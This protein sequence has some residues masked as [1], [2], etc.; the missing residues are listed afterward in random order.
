MLFL[1]GTDSGSSSLSLEAS[2]AEAV[3]SKKESLTLSLFSVDSVAVDRM[4]T[5]LGAGYKLVAYL[6]GSLSISAIFG[7]FHEFF[8]VSFNLILTY[9]L[10]SSPLNNSGA[11]ARKQSF[12]T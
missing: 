11:T 9:D 1:A 4:C 5:P 3:R 7:D 12:W 6:A 8:K 10:Q 2:G